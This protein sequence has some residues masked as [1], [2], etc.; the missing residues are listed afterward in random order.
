MDATVRARFRLATDRDTRLVLCG[1]RDK[2]G[3]ATCPGAFGVQTPL[4]GGPPDMRVNGILRPDNKGIYRPTVRAL[5]ERAQGRPIRLRRSHVRNSNYPHDEHW[6][7]IRDLGPQGERAGEIV[8]DFP[9]MAICP[10]CLTLNEI[11]H[12]SHTA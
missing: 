4:H 6:S 11:Q 2:A 5:E 3:R 12:F 10:R 1:K 9:I 8:Y 7:N